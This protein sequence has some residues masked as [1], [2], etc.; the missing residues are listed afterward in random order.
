MQE[1]IVAVNFVL[2]ILAVLHLTLFIFV[3][4]IHHN[5]IR[6]TVHYKSS[7]APKLCVLF[8]VSPKL[9]VVRTVFERYFFIL[10]L[11]MDYFYWRNLC[12]ANKKIT[13]FDKKYKFWNKRCLYG[14]RNLYN[15]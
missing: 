8:Y 7:G 15:S 4:N 13:I 2:M 1:N 5:F 11:S 14:T 3:I 12:S 10:L 9:C 6:C